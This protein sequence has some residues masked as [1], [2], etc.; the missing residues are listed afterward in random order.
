M[1][2][3]VTQLRFNRITHLPISFAQTELRAG[4]TII[5]AAFNLLIGQRMEIRSLTLNLMRVL[6]NGAVP[7][8]R[9]TAYKTC[10]IGLYRGVTDC[11]PLA[12]AAV[13]SMGTTGMNCFRR[14]I[15]EAPGDYRIAVRNNTLNVDLSVAA[16]GAVKIY[17]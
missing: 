14:V 13:D 3:F 11:S 16:T 4:K 7:A 1:N 15:I 5:V 2:G 12:F 6:T 10:I 17:Y 8:S 9:Y